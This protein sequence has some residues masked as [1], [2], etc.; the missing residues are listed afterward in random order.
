M[1]IK[2]NYCKPK[3]IDLPTLEKQF[4]DDQTKQNENRMLICNDPNPSLYQYSPFAIQ[5]LQLYNPIYPRFFEMTSFF[6]TKRWK[7]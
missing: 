3:P 2:I 5:D 1:S 7:R 6:P 4:L